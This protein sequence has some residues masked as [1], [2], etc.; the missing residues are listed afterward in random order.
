MTIRVGALVNWHDIRRQ[1]GTVVAL[2]AESGRAVVRWPEGDETSMALRHLTVAERAYTIA[3]TLTVGASD[4]HLQ[5]EQAIRD[6]VRSW[7]EGLGATVHAV[8]VHSEQESEK[9][10]RS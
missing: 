9:E 10:E 8:S 5:D 3:V 7:F 4:E 1:R 2:D 6:E